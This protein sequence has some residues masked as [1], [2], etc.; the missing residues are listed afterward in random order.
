V[1]KA[2][3]GWLDMPFAR[4]V[5]GDARPAYAAPFNSNDA[6]KTVRMHSIVPKD[7]QAAIVL[8]AVKGEA[9]ARQPDGR[10]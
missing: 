2:A 9:L 7:R 8:A 1:I 3:S 6:A 10:P 5:A 4:C